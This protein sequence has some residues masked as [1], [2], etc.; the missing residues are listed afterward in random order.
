MNIISHKNITNIN[1]NKVNAYYISEKLTTSP[2]DFENIDNI[3]AIKNP[4]WQ[5]KLLTL[6]FI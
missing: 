1:K 6:L 5:K 4:Y 2:M 3:C